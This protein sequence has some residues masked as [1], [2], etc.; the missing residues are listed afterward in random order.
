MSLLSTIGTASARAYGFTRSVV[1][2]VKDSFF[3]RVTLLLNTSSTNGAQNNTFLDSSSNN[4]TITRNGNTTQGTFT[5]F[6]QTGWSN[7]QGAS[8]YQTAP[9]NAA[10]ALGTNNWTIDCWVYPTSFGTYNFIYNRASG[11]TNATTEIEVL[12]NSSGTVQCSVYSGSTG[13]A[14]SSAANLSLNQW[15]HLAFVRNGTSLQIYINGVASGSSVNVSTVSLNNTSSTPYIG[16]QYIGGR[17]LV[18]YISNFR[19]V[20]GTAVYTGNFTP[21]TT[22]LTNITNTVLLTNQSNRFIDNSTANSGS[23]WTL[24]VGGTP[25]VQ[26]FS[27]FAPTAAYS[28]TTVGGSGYFD[29]SGDYLQNPAAASNGVGT[30]NYTLE[31][32]FY[33]NSAPSSGADRTFIRYHWTG[34]AGQNAVYYL[35]VTNS[36]GT[37]YPYTYARDVT[38]SSNNT[39]VTSSTAVKLYTWNHV[40]AVRSG[41]TLTLYLNGVSVGS[42]TGVSWNITAATNIPIYIGTYNGSSEMMDGYILGAR[43]VK[44]AVYSGST[45][46]IPTAPPTSDANTQLLLNFTNAGIYDAAAKNDLETVGNAQVSTTQAKFGTTSMY[47]DG[48]GDYML[49]PNNPIINLS[50]DFTIEAWV[51]RNTT[52]VNTIIMGLG[53][54]ATSANGFT[55]YISTTN[56]I[57]MYGN[58]AVIAIGS[59]TTIPANT[60]TYVAAVRSG[61]GTNNL[62]LYVD[63]VVQAQATNNTSFVGVAA[64]GLSVG[65]WYDGTSIV[66]TGSCYIDELRIT[67]GYARTVTTNPTAA[68]PT[69]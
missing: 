41:T 42:A 35:S 58:G 18:G 46:T 26:A 3:N 49:I 6:S 61:T 36:A 53:S 47:F 12:L 66:A 39:T 33:L 1:T 69:Q 34:S 2:T 28:T 44:S 14:A 30:G 23:P 29:G 52:G 56:F 31:C 63:G 27:P 5:P 24:T 59:T 16:N 19:L 38:T 4:F 37:L 8:D 65:A 57:G 60:W 7:Y 51:Y 17:G 62:K 32:W 21:S 13:Y 9:A 25:S 22:P 48:T 45:Y 64:N 68:F 67:K 10:F 15:A 43:V 20:N 11:S 50:G 55:F 54:Y 40:A